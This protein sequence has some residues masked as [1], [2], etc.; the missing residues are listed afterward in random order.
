M[1]NMRTTRVVSPTNFR[2]HEFQCGVRIADCLVPVCR[3]RAPVFALVDKRSY[4]ASVDPCQHPE[5]APMLRHTWMAENTSV[6]RA[7]LLS[8]ILCHH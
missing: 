5:G 4:S 7:V 2:T 3:K 6:L 8:S 1:R